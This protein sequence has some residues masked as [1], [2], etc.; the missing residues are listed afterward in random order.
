MS[1]LA[2]LIETLEASLPAIRRDLA[3]DDWAAFTRLLAEAAPFFAHAE[4][5]PDARLEAIYRLKDACAAFAATRRVLPAP[6]GMI[7]EPRPE[8]ATGPVVSG[9]L[10][11]LDELDRMF[12]QSKERSE[13]E[14][15][16]IYRGIQ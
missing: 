12:G 3:G 8:P 16:R 5:D 2:T 11:D 9:L 1:D 6:G 15:M 13:R 7:P 4:V 14:A 10:I